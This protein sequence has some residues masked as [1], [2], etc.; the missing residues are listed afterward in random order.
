MFEIKNDY[1]G[2]DK[3]MSSLDEG[4]DAV[5][6]HGATFISI[7]WIVVKGIIKYYEDSLRL[8]T[9]YPQVIKKM[10]GVWID[11][12]N[13][14]IKDTMVILDSEKEF[15]KDVVDMFAELEKNDSLIQKMIE[16]IE[17]VSDLKRHKD[18]KTELEMEFDTLSEVSYQKRKKY[19]ELRE[20][21]FSNNVGE[22]TIEELA[23]A[24][25]A[26]KKA[27]K[28][29]YSAWERIA[30]EKRRKDEVIEDFIKSKKPQKQTATA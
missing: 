5:S 1:L 21:Y 10:V 6:K 23:E 29:S 22:V 4:I 12:I 30:D 20:S 15:C 14:G 25:E 27:E 26:M 13:K 24:Q 16:A 19:E 3:M 18:S 2:K 9:K 28:E 8:V 7:L 17:P 11:A